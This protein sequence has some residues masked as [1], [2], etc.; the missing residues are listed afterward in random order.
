MKF[1]ICATT[2]TSHACII[3]LYSNQLQYITYYAVSVHILPVVVSVCVSVVGQCCQQ[4]CSEC[5]SDPDN[6]LQQHRPAQKPQLSELECSY[7]TLKLWGYH[8]F[9]LFAADIQRIFPGDLG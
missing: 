6:C 8:L 4:K 5:A 7:K 1:N 9:C 2:A 3:T